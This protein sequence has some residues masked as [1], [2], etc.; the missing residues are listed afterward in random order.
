MSKS[1]AGKNA[2]KLAEKRD[3]RGFLTESSP[4]AIGAHPLTGPE[5]LAKLAGKYILSSAK[6][7]L[8]REGLVRTPDRFAAALESLTEGYLKPPL[9]HLFLLFLCMQALNHSLK[10]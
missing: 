1:L 10:D 3:H 8:T 6:E 7:D 9:F 5:N 2:G 4:G